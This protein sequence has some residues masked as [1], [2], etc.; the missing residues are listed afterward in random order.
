[1][2]SVVGKVYNGR[3]INTMVQ[4]TTWSIWFMLS[5]IPGA[6]GTETNKTNKSALRKLML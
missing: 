2:L 3:S 6:G 4:H 1:M 5:P